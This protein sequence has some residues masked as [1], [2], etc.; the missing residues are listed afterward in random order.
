MGKRGSKV[1][2]NCQTGNIG[3]RSGWCPHCGKGFIIK[4]V[5]QPDVDPALLN[6]GTTVKKKRGAKAPTLTA[7]QFEQLLSVKPASDTNPANIAETTPS[8]V[9][10]IAS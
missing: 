1:C 5:Q 4:G 3:V 2:S 9:S 8:P 10:T 6:K 7:E